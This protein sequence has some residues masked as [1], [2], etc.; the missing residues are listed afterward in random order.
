[1]SRKITA[2]LSFMLFMWLAGLRAQ[3]HGPALRFHSIEQAGLAEGHGAAAGI[4]QS[5]NGMAL[6]TW[7][8]GIGIGID[9]YRYRSV[10]L[11]L[12]LRKELGQK[13][14]KW[15]IYAEAGYNFPWVHEAGT[16][17]YWNPIMKHE[18]KYKGKIYADVGAGY[19][20]HCRKYGTFLMILGYSR[21]DFDR[22]VTT[23][24][25]GSENYVESYSY[26]F[27]RLMIKL[28]WEF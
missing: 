22:I 27:N 17:Y 26:K 10:P 6:N 14:N 5:I 19:A 12:D 9:G 4:I 8:A 23:V 18:Y 21:K 20:I 3:Q 28:G 7:F 2:C 24:Y 16:Q 15:L 1:M 11:F 25:P 13:R